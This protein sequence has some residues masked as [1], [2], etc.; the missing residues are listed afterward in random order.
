M[1]KKKTIRILLLSVLGAIAIF[2]LFLF[3][4]FKNDNPL[5]QP[6]PTS[7]ISYE[8]T[9]SIASTPEFLGASTPEIKEQT[10]LICGDTPVLTILV[11]GIDYRID[12]YLYG[13]ADSIHIVRIDFSKPEI[14]IF[15]IDRDIWVDIP[16]ISDHYGITQGKLNQA[17]FYGVP[18]MGYYDGPAGGAGLLALTLNQNFGFTLDNYIVID[19]AAFE[20][21]VDA[22][23]GID[24]YLPTYVDGRPMPNGQGPNFGYFSAGFHHLSGAQALNLARIRYKYSSLIRMDNQEI[25]IKGLFDKLKNPDVILKIPSLMKIIN[26]SVKMDLT[27][28]KIASLICLAGKIDLS[29]VVFAEVPKEYYKES[30]HYDPYFHF[31]DFIYDIDFNVI[32]SYASKF[33]NGELP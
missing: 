20:R 31:W 13:L 23:G 24:I 17:Y 28:S 25:I 14:S 4:Y 19:M 1:K 7:N 26:D 21:I 5:E 33:V 10:K 30:S 12:N 8:S 22:V 32:R 11:A 15:S 18:A 27:P 3:F 29:K 16:D 9:F 2:I 6:L